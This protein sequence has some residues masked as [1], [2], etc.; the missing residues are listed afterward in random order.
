VTEPG[1]LHVAVC[2]AVSFVAGAVDAMAG[3]GGIL[4]MPAL[5]SFGIPIGEVAGT[6]K[7]VGT[8]GSSTA[9]L[10]FLLRGKVERT[11]AALGGVTAAA[12]AVGGAL[13]LAHLGEVNRRLAAGIFGVLLV[14]IALYLF[15]RKQVGGENAYAGPTAR[16]LAITVAAGLGIGFYDGFFGPGTGSFLVFVMV[17]WLRFDYVT[18]TGNAK[19]MNFGSNV[20]SL[21]TF[22]AKGLVVWPLAIPM[23]VANAAGSWVGSTV[24]I[25]KGARFVRWVFLAAAVAVAGRMLAALLAGR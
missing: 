4:T 13:L 9:T 5:A 2:T 22:V 8:S 12:G 23:A 19:C 3:G 14:T 16:N 1:L 25:A 10:T 6:N 7:V 24:A 15:F 20:A 17:R 11:I 21:A 18:G